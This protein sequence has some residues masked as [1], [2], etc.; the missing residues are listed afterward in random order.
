MLGSTG[1]FGLT[2]VGRMLMLQDKAALK[3]WLAQEAAEP[4][5]ALVCV[6]HGEPVIADAAKKMREAAERL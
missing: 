6:S 4:D 2:T 5:L 1:F 3:A